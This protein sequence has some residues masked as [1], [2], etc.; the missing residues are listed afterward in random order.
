MGPLLPITPVNGDAHQPEHQGLRDH[1]ASWRVSSILIHIETLVRRV[2]GHTARCSALG[3]AWQIVMTNTPNITIELLGISNHLI[4]CSPRQLPARIVQ[5]LDQLRRIGVADYLWLL[6]TGFGLEA[7]SDADCTW[8]SKGAA[9]LPKNLEKAIRQRCKENGV[10]KA[11]QLSPITADD[12][13]DSHIQHCHHSALLIT[14]P[15]GALVLGWEGPN[16]N[17]GPANEHLNLIANLMSAVVGRWQQERLRGN[18]SAQGQRD[19]LSVSGNQP[20]S[21]AFRAAVGSGVDEAILEQE[22]AASTNGQGLSRALSLFEIINRGSEDIISIHDAQGKCLYVSDACIE[23]LGFNPEKLIGTR[24]HDIIHPQFHDELDKNIADMIDKG[25]SKSFKCRVKD[26]KGTW[27]MME[28]RGGIVRDKSNRFTEMVMVF[29][30]M[31]DRFLLEEN[32]RF[33]EQNLQTILENIPDA[34]WFKD[35]NGIILSANHSCRGIFGAEADELIGRSEHDFLGVADTHRSNQYDEI[36]LNSAEGISYTHHLGRY[37]GAE[38]IWEIHKEPLFD[39]N[40]EVTGICTQA[41]NASTEIDLQVKLIH[42]AGLIQQCEEHH[43]IG[44]WSLDQDMFHTNSTFAKLC[45]LESSCDLDSLE[46][47]LTMVDARQRPFIE[48][49]LQEAVELQRPFCIDLSLHTNPDHMRKV[50]L[51]GSLVSN[52]PEHLQ[53]VKGIISVLSPTEND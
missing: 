11:L 37:E 13:S 24:C 25:S 12:F 50:R 48:H 51:S 32:L 6:T 17:L 10:R 29:R 1:R 45:G 43:R 28:V 22:L 41:H 21:S 19:N 4:N 52:G 42:S 30:D 26:A 20:L 34:I 9:P 40:G 5:L 31:S 49:A 18:E 35:Q 15:Q 16:D 27:R 14:G 38:A 47:F 23:I 3:A 8:N 7:S 36:V 53:S 39:K 46:E 2:C 44:Y 33:S